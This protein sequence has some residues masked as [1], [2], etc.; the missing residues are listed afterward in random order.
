MLDTKNFVLRTGVRT[1]EAAAFLRGKGADTVEVKR[2]F[3]NSISTYKTKYKLVSEAEIFNFYAIACA[4]EETSDIRIAAAQ[5]ADELL[6]IENVKASF[7]MFP[8]KN[9]INISARSLGD[10]NVQ[11]L[12]EKM[13]GGGHQTMAATQLKGVTMEEA[14][15]QLVQIVSSI[16]SEQVQNQTESAGA[17]SVFIEPQQ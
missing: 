9:C 16:N 3:S 14:R 8:T 5:A 7:V 2:L 11:V 13:G 10:V 15:E 17:E 1:F 4:D 12:M 6:G